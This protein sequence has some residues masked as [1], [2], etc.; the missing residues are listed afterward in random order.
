[1]VKSD[2]SSIS[3][4]QQQRDAV[5]YRGGTLLVSAAA[6]SG[7]TKVLVERVMEQI[8]HEGKNIDEFL[9]ITFTNAAAA[10]L[11]MKISDAITGAA[12]ELTENRHLSQQKSR[13]SRTQ[14]STIHAFCGSIVRESGYLVDIAQDCKMIEE[15]ERERILEDVIEA[16]L[17]ECYTEARP[18][19]LLLVDKFGSGRN[20]QALVTLIH[21]LLDAMEAQPFPFEWLKKQKDGLVIEEKA[22]LNNTAWGQIITRY[23]KELLLGEAEKYDCALKA[24]SGDAMLEKKYIPAYEEIRDKLIDTANKMDEP[25]DSLFP[26]FDYKVPSP[27]VRGYPDKEF[28]EAVKNIKAGTRKMLAKCAGYFKR[29]AEELIAEQNEMAGPVAYLLDMTENIWNRFSAEKRRKNVMDFSDQEQLAISILVGPDGKPSAAAKQISKRYTEIMVDEYQDSNRVQETIFTAISSEGDKNRFLVGDVKQ[30]IYGFR[31]AEPGMFLERY[32]NSLPANECGEGESGKLVLTRNFRSRKE[33]LGAVNHVFSSILSA[34]TGDIEYDKDAALYP[35]LNEYPSD[36]RSHVE[37]ALIDLETEED[38]EE[39]INNS[40]ETDKRDIEAIWAANRITE[41]LRDGIEVRDGDRTRP[42]QAKDIAILFRTNDSIEHFRRIF[43]KA[44][45]PVSTEAGENIFDAKEIQEVMN[46]IRVLDNPHQDIALYSLLTSPLFNLTD[47][48]LAEIRLASPNG[49]LYDALRKLEKGFA[50]DAADRITQMRQQVRTL[51]GDRIIWQLLIDMDLMEIYAGQND[52]RK[53]LKRLER[54]CEIAMNGGEGKNL[55]ELATY[56]E[57]QAEKGCFLSA[58]EGNAVTLTTIHKSK[59]LEYPVVFLACLGASLPDKDSKKPVIIDPE[60]GFGLRITNTETRTWH[61][62]IGLDAMKIRTSHRSRSEEMRVLYVAMTR[63]KDYLIMMISDKNFRKKVEKL[64][65]GAGM[66][67]RRWAVESSESMGDWIL[68]SALVRMECGILSKDSA[69]P[70]EKAV[71]EDAWKVNITSRTELEKKDLKLLAKENV[72]Q[73]REETAVGS[74]KDKIFDGDD[75]KYPHE[76]ACTIASKLTATALKKKENNQAAFSSAEN[77][78]LQT[79][80][81]AAIPTIHLRRP[82]F[83]K[84]K[85]LTAAEKGTAAHQFLQYAD[86]TALSTKDGIVGEL[87]RMV[88]FAYLTEAQAASIDPEMILRLFS[89]DIGRRILTAEK[90]IREFK[91]SILVDA[92]EYYPEMKDSAEQILLQGV[93]DAAIFED[94]GITVIDFKTDRIKDAG[95]RAEEYRPQLQ[96]YKK[97]MEKIWGMPVKSCIVIF[98]STGQAVTLS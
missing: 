24:M 41:M 44:G 74:E 89:S 96:V 21:S 83:L 55:N 70:C 20:D 28:L 45:I 86:Y 62:G 79:A 53:K 46:L 69:F 80:G 15:N 3:L 51:S 92:G 52:G 77:K 56:L 25:W 11:R 43:E 29:C 37:L 7:K 23:V 94:D 26:L 22:E 34:E 50:R 58:E 90:L 67:C 8:L 31:R 84:K 63:P 91:F 49:K 18:D 5:I 71:F 65:P 68:L 59:G 10:E 19:F 39:G 88:D 6:G 57:L 42:V 61:R 54:F 75:W 85:G 97:A 9:I 95:K 60:L 12:A 13:L 48:Q 78:Q 82:E 32:A 73:I 98:L 87:D 72:L 76:K 16:V 17:E 64:I 1:M 35:G 2:M 40:E 66:P 38:E 36:N 14:I 4:T 47:N 27:S 93:V 81:E 33:I 30:S